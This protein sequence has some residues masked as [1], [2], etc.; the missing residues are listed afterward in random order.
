MLPAK[1]KAVSMIVPPRPTE[2][3]SKLGPDTPWAMQSVSVR[4]GKEVRFVRFEPV[5]KPRKVP[6]PTP[7]PLLPAD[8]PFATHTLPPAPTTTT[9]REPSPIPERSAQRL[10]S[11]NYVAIEATSRNF[12]LI[13]LGPINAYEHSVVVHVPK[14]RIPWAILTSI[15]PGSVLSVTKDRGGTIHHLRVR[16]ITPA[17][18]YSPGQRVTSLEVTVKGSDWWSLMGNTSRI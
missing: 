6:W 3:V 12:G 10:G 2:V 17:K 1:K 4:K 11:K 16:T 15:R 8:A 18:Y 9:K 5:H 7:A 13:D 14:N